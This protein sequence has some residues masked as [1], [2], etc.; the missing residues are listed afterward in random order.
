[1]TKQLKIGMIFFIAAIITSGVYFIQRNASKSAQAGYILYDDGD[2]VVAF[3]YFNQ[4]AD[5]D[6]QSAFS[7]AMMYWNGVG[8]PQNKPLAIQW[9]TQ[10]ANEGNRSA[11]YN[12]G[13][14]RYQ[15]DIPASDDDPYGLTSLK[16]AAD[17]GVLNAQE[18]LGSIYIEDKH[19][20]I[21]QDYELA[22]HY[23]ND[24]TQQDSILASFALGVIAYQHDKDYKKAVEILEP[25]ATDNFLFS[26][27][28]KLS[29]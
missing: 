21:S 18:L 20:Q 24:A 17:L 12:L 14:F 23:L 10:S 28:N 8:T 13:Y 19:K 29:K 27:I 3:N 4:H 5:T 9:L 1:M 15:K 22:R 7:L 26:A 11:L 16:K 6:P 25:L 2:T